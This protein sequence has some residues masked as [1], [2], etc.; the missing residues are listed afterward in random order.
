MNFGLEWVVRFKKTVFLQRNKNNV[1]YFK[2]FPFHTQKIILGKSTK[3]NCHATSQKI[4]VPSFTWS[5]I[6]IVGFGYCAFASFCANKNW[7]L[8]N[9]NA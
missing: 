9:A 1:F 6:A 3:N 5:D 2:V 7:K 8:Y 4:Y